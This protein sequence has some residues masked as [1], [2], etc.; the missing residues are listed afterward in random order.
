M[1][2]MLQIA[3]RACLGWF[4]GWT[5]LLSIVAAFAAEPSAALPPTPGQTNRNFVVLGD[6]LA[7]GYGVDLSEAFPAILQKQFKASGLDYTVVN[8]GV[9]GDT[10]AGALR[11]LDWIL[12][13][14]VDVLL[15]EVGGNDG[16]RGQTPAS[17]KTN[18]QSIIERTRKKYPQA[19]IVLAGMR[20][21]P[22]MGS[23]VEQ[24]D[25]LYAEVAAEQKV[26][27]VPFLLAGVGGVR[28]LNQEDGIHPTPEGHRK[29]ATNVFEVVKPLLEKRAGP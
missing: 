20:M 13:R 16:L 8:A 18:L 11:R 22:N 6:S 24:F 26:A 5:F 23:Y 3:T 28:E 29:I 27:L 9:S 10:S 7:A 25:K 2:L 17:T 14:P 12:R 4:L 15:V 21:P 1:N 19:Q